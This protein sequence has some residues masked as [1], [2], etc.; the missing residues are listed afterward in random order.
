MA[1]LSLIGLAGMLSLAALRYHTLL[2]KRPPNRGRLD[3]FALLVATGGI[4]A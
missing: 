3:T 2:A 4:P 1:Q